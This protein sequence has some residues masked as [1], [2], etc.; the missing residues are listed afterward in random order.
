M[1]LILRLLP[2]CLLCVSCTER[3]PWVGAENSPCL[4]NDTCNDSLV[5]RGGLCVRS[6]LPPFD[7][8]TRDYTT[9]DFSLPENDLSQPDQSNCSTRPAP[10]LNHP[11][12]TPQR[13]AAISGSAPGAVSFVVTIGNKVKEIKTKS[14]FCAEVDLPENVTS[15]VEVYAVFTDGCRSQSAVASIRQVKLKPINLIAGKY[16]AAYRKASNNDKIS[17]LTDRRYDRAV[18]F[19]FFDP[20]VTTNACDKYAYARWDLGQKREI[21]GATVHYPKSTGGGKFEAFLTCWKFLV[22]E[23]NSSQPP[24]PSPSDTKWKLAAEAKT[25]TNQTLQIS[26]QPMSVRHVA[27]LMFEDGASDIY[28]D[29]DITEVEVWGQ[30]NVPPFRGCP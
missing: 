19:S 7:L 23:V 18:A 27:L 4:P 6:T 12:E 5:C 20:D 9:R 22:S 30:P 1:N 10:S 26:F 21:I 3:L 29:F 8:G 16:G 24:Y 17:W 28:E 14:A 2:L 15:N 11:K 25:G 13:K